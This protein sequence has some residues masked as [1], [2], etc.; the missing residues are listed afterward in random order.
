MSDFTILPRIQT[1]TEGYERHYPNIVE[2]VHVQMEEKFWLPNE[3]KVELDKMT[4]EY[5]LSPKQR[6]AVRF[7]L[8]LF[9]QYELQVGE[10]WR[11]VGDIF[12]RPEVKMAAVVVEMIERY[13]HAEFYDKINI[14][15]GL[16]KDEH[17]LAF[18]E[19]PILN[20]RMKYLGSLLSPE[21]K[22]QILSV[23]IFSLT[24]TV[25][26]FSSF[27]ILKS[28]QSNGLNLIPVIVRGTN[29]S[30]LDEDQHGIILSEIINTYYSEIGT[31]LF[32]DKIRY[33]QVVKAIEYCVNNELMILEEAIPDGE[34]NGTTVEEY[35]DYVKHRANIYCD[36]LG[37]PRLYP[38]V[39]S[40][41]AGWFEKNTY[42]YQKIDFFTTGQGRE[43]EVGWDEVGFSAAW[44][45]EVKEKSSDND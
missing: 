16:D 13:V 21:A 14:V 6:H 37:I 31:T 15:L 28:F 2:Q 41:V 5:K 29:Q 40:V 20:E 32:E 26:L 1:P 36:R 25:S 34:L 19:N 33:E 7:V 9:V 10:M 44:F 17:Y 8:N 38:N 35:F 24:E 12:P 22:D 3:M 11:R 23:I 42:A 27:S 18:T 45:D 4:L 39:N 30:S 43:Y